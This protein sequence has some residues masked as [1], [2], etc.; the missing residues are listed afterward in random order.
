MASRLPTVSRSFRGSNHALRGGWGMLT[1]VLLT[2]VACLPVPQAQTVPTPRYPPYSQSEYAPFSQ[3]GSSSIIGQAFMRTRGGDVKVGA[4][5]EVTLDPSTPLSKSWWEQIGMLWNAR[6]FAPP[7]EM[8]QY[9]K[10][11]IAD[12]TGRFHFEKLPA[13]TYYVRSTV[14]WEAP[15]AAGLALQGGLVGKEV[16]V[17]EGESV[18]VILTM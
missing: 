6:S 7:S 11:V 13:G 10:T 3:P 5:S 12:A 16:P 2:A 17:R 9:R 4:G 15:T 14:T 8:L 1:A 18:E